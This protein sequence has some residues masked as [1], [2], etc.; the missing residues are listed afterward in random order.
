[1]RRLIAVMVA[2]AVVSFAAAAAGIDVRATYGARTTGDEPYYLITAVTLWDDRD[3][4]IS[5]E[6]EVGAFRAWHEIPLDEQTKSL[7]GGGRVS[8]HDPLLPALLAPAVALGG[9]VGAKLVLAALAGVL[10]ALIVWIAVR[11]FGVSVG[12]AGLT[13]GVFGASAPLAVYGNQVYPELPAALCVA[14]ALAGL[15]GRPPKAGGL[16]ALAAAISALP[17]LSVKYV[18]VAAILAVLGV[19]ALWR[20]GRRR[21][22]TGF[23]GALVL[24]GIA[25]VLG[26]LQWYGGVTPY[27][28]GDHFTSGEFSVIGNQP[29]YWGRARRLLGLLVDRNFGLVAW[30]PAWFLIVPAATAVL[31]A[32]PG[33]WGALVFPLA[34]G[35]LNATF[36]ALTMQGW[37]WPGRQVVVV[38]PCAVV[39]I[40]YWAN[41]NRARLIALALTGSL[42]IVTLVWLLADG[43]NRR[44]TWVVDFYDTTNPLYGVWRH[45]LPDYLDVTSMTWVLH[46]AWL[47]LVLAVAE[48][49]WRGMAPVGGVGSSRP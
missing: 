20:A 24:M 26:H 4:D 8:P 25:F 14:V 48:R 13:A 27:A 49:T 35:W 17:W 29:N 15:T 22:L 45:V 39:C 23:I 47:V 42:G 30:Q 34:V 9:W 37:W 11:R 44:I 41:N 33:Q 43:L 12:A 16:V 21:A 28:V 31:R 19:I 36:V 32:R 1:M 3:L 5:D 6:I 18:P 2:V 40:A 46:G 10:A 38:L 7:E